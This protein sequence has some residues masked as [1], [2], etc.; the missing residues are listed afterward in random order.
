MIGILDAAY[1][2]NRVA[3]A[4]VVAT[5][6]QTGEAH[7]EYF[8]M[9]DQVSPYEPGQFYRRELPL[10]LAAIHE[11]ETSIDCVVVDGYVWLR[12]DS[13]RGLGAHLYEALVGRVPVIGV[14]K[15]RV[16]TRQR[17][18]C[19]VGKASVRSTSRQQALA[20]TSR[21]TMSTVCMGWAE[22]RH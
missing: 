4:C 20:S 2:D 21:P 5:C 16:W 22:S 7:R 3:A 12:P 8:A 18:R 11:V 6:W 13:A 14:A 17:R 15:T 9:R 1:G 19:C 10:L